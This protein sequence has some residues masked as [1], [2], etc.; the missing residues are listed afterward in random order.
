M[1]NER[2]PS[3]EAVEAAIC[4]TIMIL[5]RLTFKMINAKNKKLC[6]LFM[7][8]AERTHIKLTALLALQNRE[9]AARAFYTASDH[10]AVRLSE[11][12]QTNDTYRQA[13]RAHTELFI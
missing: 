9:R 4:K 11:L 3:P 6:D 2:K 5:N 10:V 13:V 8:R 7:A 12:R 1:M